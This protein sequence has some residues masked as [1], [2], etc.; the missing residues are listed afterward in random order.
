MASTQNFTDALIG[1]SSLYQL[2]YEPVSKPKRR[3]NPKRPNNNNNNNNNKKKG[4]WNE[5]TGWILAPLSFSTHDVIAN[6]I[7]P[8]IVI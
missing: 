7:F 4:D 2:P 5:L 8:F 3:P 1:D 6:Y